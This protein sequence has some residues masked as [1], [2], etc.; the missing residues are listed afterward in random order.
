MTLDDR[1]LREHLDRRAQAG[2]VDPAVIAE[3]V[4]SRIATEDGRPSL[5][6][7]MATRAVGL[8][9]AAVAVLLVGIAVLPGRLGPAPGAS[10]TGSVPSSIGPSAAYPGD[11]PMTAAELGTFMAGDPATWASITI[12][13]DVELFPIR[14]PCFVDGACPTLWIPGP[15]GSANIVVWDTDG[16]PIQGGPYAFKVRSDGSLDVVG[17]VRRGPDRLA[18]TMPELLNADPTFRTAGQPRGLLYLVDAIQFVSDTAI[19]CPTVVASAADF[20][21]GSGWAW[22]IGTDAPLPTDPMVVP[23]DSLRVQNV[24]GF[25]LR[26]DAMHQRGFYLIDPIAAPDG[27]F[28]CGAP[29]AADVVAGVLPFAELGWDPGPLASPTVAPSTPATDVPSS[30]YPADRAMTAAELGS[31]LAGDPTARASITIVVDVE[32]QVA[33]AA[34]VFMSAGCETYWI[35]GLGGHPSIL[36]GNTDGIPI[37][38]GPYAFNVRSDGGLDLLGSVRVGPTGSTWTLP[39]LLKSDPYFRSP[40]VPPSTL[41]LVDAYL[42]APPNSIACPVAIPGVRFNCGDVAWL[43]ANGDPLP[44]DVL[45]PPPDSLRASGLDT[46]AVGRGNWL[47]RPATTPGGCFACPPAGAVD[48]LGRV[49]PFSELGFDPAQTMSPSASP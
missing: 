40:T 10:P 18:W 37:Q 19:S 28:L 17:S 3:T 42:A 13:A 38:G 6:G 30:L 9:T 8:A 44:T 29:G 49:L 41:Y 25:R 46:E 5:S 16:V 2:V 21:C 39:E 4:A 26:S 34:C 35:R 48:I 33:P 20:S 11:R 43:V 47:I 23:P 31:F 32:V 45:S 22:L 7:R 15:G 27:C 36:V 12:V 24:T 14:T 1:S